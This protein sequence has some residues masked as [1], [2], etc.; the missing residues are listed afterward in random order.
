M[1]AFVSNRGG[2]KQ[3]WVVRASGGRPRRLVKLPTDVD[4]LLWSP[5]GDRIAFSAE[6]YADGSGL[7]ETASRDKRRRGEPKAM[8]FDRLFVRHWKEWYTGKRSHLFV[9]PVRQ[10]SSAGGVVPGGEPKDL[11]GSL[12]GDCPTKPFGGREEYCW[13]PDGSEIAFVTQTGDDRAWSTDLDIYVVASRGGPPRCITDSNRASAFHPVYSPNGRWIA[14]LSM[15]RPGFEADRTRIA[16]YDRKTG[17]TK[18]LTEG[19]DRSPNS[20]AWSADSKVLVATA[21]DTAR[22]KL[23]A[24]DVRSGRTR[25]LV[26][27]HHN[28]LIAVARDNRV[29]FAQDSLVAPAD[30]WAIGLG[31][32]GVHRLTNLNRERVAAARMSEPEEFQFIGAMAEKVQAWIMKPVNFVAGR[33]YPVALIIHGGPQTATE[34]TFHYRWNLQA[35]AGAGYA[36]VAIN[37]HGSSGFGQN[38][39]DSISGDWGGK[40]FEDLMRGLDHALKTYGWLDGDR[41]AALGASF[42]GWMVNWINGHTDRFKCLV[43]HDGGFDQ[44]SFYYSTDELWFPEWEFGGTP[45]ERPELYEKFSPSRYVANW[46]T[47]TLVIHGAK[48][49]RLTE[50]EGISTFTALQRRGIPS[51]LLYF[52]NEGHWVLDARDSILWHDTILSWL[53]RWLGGPRR[54]SG[55]RAE[56]SAR[57]TAALPSI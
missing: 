2:S 33:K 12:D 38:F 31:G 15:A 39:T 37:Y 9:L 56:L 11:T 46:K 41:M 49:F 40:P 30:L 34:D 13:S 10:P 24:V 54:S 42:G 47:P 18:T 51:Q 36:V 6:V 53:D 44:F 7:Q 22:Q 14:Y 35:F 23:F 8:R 5:R 50:T 48:D 1:V 25:E 21:G 16:L 55:V 4:N 19:W 52:E 32:D 57:R 45:W 43:N 20:L 17:R 28:T 26:S 27:D 3:I 29:L